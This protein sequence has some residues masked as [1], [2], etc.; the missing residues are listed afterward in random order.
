MILGFAAEVT[1]PHKCI[2]CRLGLPTWLLALCEVWTPTGG[3]C[4]TVRFRDPSGVERTVSGNLIAEGDKG[5]IVI[6]A[7]DGRHWEIEKAD[8]RRWDESAEPVALLDRD[9]LIASLREEYG[10]GFRILETK[11]YILVYS[12]SEGFAKEAGKLFERIKSVFE[13]YIRKQA[14]FEPQQA[15]QPLIAVIFRS[16]E[17][18]IR[19]MKDVIGYAS[20]VTGGVYLP[21]TN[22]MY[23][24][25]M[26]GG[27]DEEWL[28]FATSATGKNADELAL[29]FAT[30]NLSTVIHEG[31][32]Q[33]AFNTGFHNRNVRNPLWLVEGLACLMETPEID[34]KRRWAG[35]G[36]INWDRLD[37]LRQK[38]ASIPMD[39]LNQL[40]TD[41]MFLRRGRTALTGYAEAWALS[42]FLTK[43][44]KKEYMK[45]VELVNG[46]PPVK[47]YTPEERIQDFRKAFGETPEQME[48]EFRR[49]LEKTLLKKKRPG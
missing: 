29:L 21:A 26:F 10:G 47:D 30:E 20:V 31:T 42:Y 9:G 12:T 17:E 18:Y 2:V 35:V 48:P 37:Y 15:K 32:H 25:D 13:N 44:K 4:D 23:L 46:R 24:Y 34:S 3:W 39:S 49:Y 43:T 41:D 1:V 11:N 16:Q 33:I 7:P 14:G 45:Y 28:R 38:Y 8:V 27:R 40:T 5:E 22:R 6:E 36:Q 19:W